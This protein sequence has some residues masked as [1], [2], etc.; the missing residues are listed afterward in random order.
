MA[1]YM[2]SLEDMKS[3][4]T[5]GEFFG[6]SQSVVMH[7]CTTDERQVYKGAK[8]VCKHVCSILPRN[9]N[10]NRNGIECLATDETSQ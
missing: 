4:G 5:Q 10:C 7:S 3:Y 8:H 9:D 1:A 6:T 2:I